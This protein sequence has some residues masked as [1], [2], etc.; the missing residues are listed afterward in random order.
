MDKYLMIRKWGRWKKRLRKVPFKKVK[1]IPPL[2]NIIRATASQNLRSRQDRSKKFL[3]IF[4]LLGLQ[5][6]KREINYMKTKHFTW[7]PAKMSSHLWPH[8]S[9]KKL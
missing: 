5:M 3:K 7:S 2:I 4:K 1:V 8:L 9:K 6:G